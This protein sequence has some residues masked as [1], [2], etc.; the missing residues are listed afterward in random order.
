MDKTNKLKLFIGIFYIILVSS[1]LIF[2]FSNFSYEEIASYKFIQ[3]NREYLVGLKASNLFILGTIFFL[4]TVLW[5]FLLGFGSP[6]GLLAGFIFGKYLGTF[7]AVLGCTLGA[8]FL[9]VFGSYFLKDIIKNKFLKKFYNLE[10]KF[11]RNELGFFIFYRFIGGIPFAIANL[12]PLLF[13]VSVKNF[14]IGTFIGIFPSIFIIVNIGSGLEKLIRQNQEAP[15]LLEL[16]LHPEIYTP[17]FGFFI[18]III[19]FLAKKIF[20]KKF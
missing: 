11:K 1:F 16:L 14:F 15:T 18:L 7:I 6:I 3:L 13:N 5:V 9:Y 17:I 19:T 8:T 20:F 2:I 10:E 12:I 4:L